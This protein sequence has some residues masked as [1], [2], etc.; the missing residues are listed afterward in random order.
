VHEH[1]IPDGD[2]PESRAV[3]EAGVTDA[4]EPAVAADG[5]GNLLGLAAFV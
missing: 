1:A 3:N 5:R 4:P 2:R